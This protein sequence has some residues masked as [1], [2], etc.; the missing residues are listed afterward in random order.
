MRESQS[1]NEPNQDVLGSPE[2]NIN[3]KFRVL[4]YS[5]RS[6]SEDAIEGTRQVLQSFGLE[7][8]AVAIMRLSNAETI[9]GAFLDPLTYYESSQ[10]VRDEYRADD[11]NSNSTGRSEVQDVMNSDTGRGFGETTNGRRRGWLGW[12]AQLGRK[13]QPSPDTGVENEQPKEVLKVDSPVEQTYLQPSGQ[14][15]PTAVIISPEMRVHTSFGSMTVETPEEKIVELCQIH[16][17]PFVRMTDIRQADNPTQ[18]LEDFLRPI[19]GA[20]MEPPDA[21][22]N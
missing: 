4:V 9:E 12:V 1:S 8:D 5:S 16:G 21:T 15:L 17:V 11:Y 22:T 20:Y 14:L 3:S 7:G 6:Q 18:A 13:N 2:S 19:V 10:R